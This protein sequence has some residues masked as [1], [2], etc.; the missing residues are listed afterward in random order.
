MLA[1]HTEYSHTTVAGAAA[2]RCGRC[3][4]SVCCGW[5]GGGK[6]RAWGRRVLAVRPCTCPPSPPRCPVP[7]TF[8]PHPPRQ[9]DGEAVGVCGGQRKLPVLEAEAARQL[10]AT[11]HRILSRQHESDAGRG[12][13][14][15]SLRRQARRVG[16]GRARLAFGDAAAAPE[17]S[18]RSPLTGHAFYNLACVDLACA[19]SPRAYMQAVHCCTARQ[20]HL[21]CRRRRVSRH[22]PGVAQAEVH[23]F[24]AVHTP[25]ARPA[26]LCDGDG[27][28]AGAADLRSGQR[29]GA[30]I[31]SRRRGEERR[32]RRQGRLLHP[33]LIWAHS[34]AGSQRRPL[35]DV[36]FA[37]FWASL[38]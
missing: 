11:P 14:R 7:S 2:A 30:R 32:R 37:A 12:A 17:A 4:L 15:H 6:A 34:Q 1:V 29:G 9:P 5:R 3:R 23:V 27:E 8:C 19:A 18:Y 28:V 36:L 10:L 20:T 31:G 33:A 21:G 24:V 13:G 25:E 16:G 22:G 38:G 26:A 35:R